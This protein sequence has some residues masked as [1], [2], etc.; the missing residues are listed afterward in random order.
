MVVSAVDLLKAL[1]AKSTLPR[2]HP[3]LN[4]IADLEQLVAFSMYHCAG[5]ERFFSDR[6]LFSNITSV[7]ALQPHTVRYQQLLNS[8]SL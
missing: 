2:D 1:N 3:S 7:A 5:V 4:S 8:M 6:L